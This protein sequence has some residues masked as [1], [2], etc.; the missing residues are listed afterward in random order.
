M[1]NIS[2]PDV[3]LSSRWMA[4]GRRKNKGER[5]IGRKRRRRRRKK[6]TRRSSSRRMRRNR[7][8]RAYYEG[9]TDCV[10]C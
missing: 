8:Q 6:D 2:N 10:L 1:A 7:E 3:N 4:E 9:Y 5:W